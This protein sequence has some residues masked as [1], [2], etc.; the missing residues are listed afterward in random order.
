MRL[1]LLAL[2]GC[3]GAAVPLAHS[4]D[5]DACVRAIDSDEPATA[6]V[7]HGRALACWGHGSC[8][9]IDVATGAFEIAGDWGDEGDHVGERDPRALARFEV[10]H[11]DRSVL[12]CERGVG[13][14]PIA[15][16]GRDPR[17][18]SAEPA[19]DGSKLY[20]VVALPD[21]VFVDTYDR[22][23][24]RIGRVRIPGDPQHGWTLNRVA[25]AVV[26]GESGMDTTAITYRLVDPFT[27]A[28]RALAQGTAVELDDH[29][30]LV[31]EG[32]SA[33]IVE[34]RTLH[35]LAT[36]V[37][38]G[39]PVFDHS[40]ASGAVAGDVAV[41]VFT[42]PPSLVAVDVRRHQF[43]GSWRIPVCKPVLGPPRA[44]PVIDDDPT[45][46]R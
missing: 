27:G 18:I 15:I 41:V 24:R 2:V 31:V 29:T 34:T 42:A 7:V 20:A 11:D 10:A 35:P 44:P 32:R 1:T 45:S 3:G 23:A 14:I 28:V 5:R 37:A 46:T 21:G 16:P 40:S 12:L 33:S 19:A 26:L 4:T 17:T 8:V 13:C 22:A 25:G 9:S 43:A 38:P 36:H 30:A 6:A 39:P